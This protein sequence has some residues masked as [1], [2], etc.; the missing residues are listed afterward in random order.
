LVIAVGLVLLAG[1]CG[2][3]HHGGGDRSKR[4]QYLARY[5]FLFA[6]CSRG[7]CVVTLADGQQFR[8]VG[9]S[10]RVT[11]TPNGTFI[12]SRCA[13]RTDATHPAA[14]TIAAL[15]G[16]PQAAL[17][18]LGRGRSSARY[19]ITA[20]SPP[21]H[22]YDVR[23]V[24]PVSAAIGVRIRTWYATSLSVFDSTGDK[25]WCNTHSAMSI[26]LLR[27]PRL[28]AQQAGPW[29]VIVSKRSQPAAT[30]RIAV[31]FSKPY[32]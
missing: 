5:G 28:E 11:E 31:T 12:Q 16:R 32:R 4:A 7:E 27:F 19:T 23:V 24:A 10:Q 6:T 17:L 13:P 9:G 18:R 8:C 29:T 14:A 30:V 20:L 26:C 2:G 22:T 3:S 15:A 25:T 1:G 21:T